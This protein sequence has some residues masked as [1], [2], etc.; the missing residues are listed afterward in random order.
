MPGKAAKFVITER[1]HS[2]LQ[3]I[4]MA[5][6]S[7][8]RMAQ[9]ARITLLAFEGRKNEQI[10]AEVEMNPDQVG[11]WRKRWKGAFTQLVAVECNESRDGLRKAI[12]QVLA[13]E[14]RSG[15]RRRIT[16]EQQAQL[17]A[18]ACE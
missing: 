16:P 1:Q 3:E 15:R 6:A 8:V 14:Q 5:R 9:R 12:L 2:G 13:D 10:G 4:F 7:E 11:V 17:V 18:L